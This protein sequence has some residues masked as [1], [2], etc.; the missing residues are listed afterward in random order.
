LGSRER[1]YCPSLFT[2]TQERFYCRRMRHSPSKRSQIQ[3]NQN[4][5]RSRLLRLH[6]ARHQVT[7]E[8]PWSR[9]GHLLHL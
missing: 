3:Q 8:P 1:T 9:K 7:A 2:L 4:S 5:G 6:T